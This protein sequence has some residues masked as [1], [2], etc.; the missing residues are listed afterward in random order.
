[1][2]RT[3]Q[4]HAA[5]NLTPVIVSNRIG[6]ETE[7]DFSITF[8]GSSFIADHTGAKVKEA[9][10]TEETVLVHTFDL[11]EVAATR[12]AWGVFRD[13][14]IDIYDALLTKDGKIN[15]ENSK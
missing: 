7:G 1:W 2:Q 15:P 10:E 11:D 5:A 3:Q 4:G 9:N 8:Y 14:R 12:R 13:R 6:T